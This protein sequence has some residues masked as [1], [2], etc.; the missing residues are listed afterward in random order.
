M[1][2][3]RSDESCRSFVYARVGHG[4]RPDNTDQRQGAKDKAQP[5]EIPK[6]YLVYLGLPPLR[7][8]NPEEIAEH[9]DDPKHPGQHGEK[10]GVDIAFQHDAAPVG[11]RITAADQS[12]NSVVTK[13]EGGAQI[14]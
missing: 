7:I 3:E 13:I 8:M 12:A 2:N 4:E 10:H 9:E 11:A 14:P 6:L 5:P 1:Q